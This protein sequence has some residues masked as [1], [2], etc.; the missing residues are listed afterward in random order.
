MKLL[1]MDLTEDGLKTEGEGNDYVVD[2]ADKKDFSSLHYYLQDLRQEVGQLM[3]QEEEIAL[4]IAIEQAEGETKNELRNKFITKNLRLVI[5]IAKRYAGRLHGL[6][7]PDLIQEG[8]TGLFRAVE[9]FDYHKGFKFST[10][11]VWWIRQSIERAIIDQASLIRLPVNVA[12]LLNRI[13]RATDYFLS[14]N[15]RQPTHTEISKMTGLPTSK[16]EEVLKIK[17]GL[18]QIDNPLGDEGDTTAH[19][20]VVCENSTKALFEV[21]NES[22]AGK[23]WATILKE[24]ILADISK[25]EKRKREK[26]L[27]VLWLLYKENK[28]FEEIVKILGIRKEQVRNRFERIMRILKQPNILAALQKLNHRGGT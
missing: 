20:K 19:E 9:K 4:A 18:L 17:K 11:A 27:E 14:E 21:E 8:N 5:S 10:Y 24:V 22:L 6:P 3:T 2:E 26:G 12:E 23:L 25:K 7:L 15:H 1:N 13:S 28:D 16:I